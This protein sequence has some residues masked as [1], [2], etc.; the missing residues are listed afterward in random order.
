MT[1]TDL[2]LV[3]AL[4]SRQ[5]GILTLDDLL[6][7]G[8][9][10][11][12]T[13]SW[14]RTGRLIQVH[15]GVYRVAGAP[16]SFESGAFAAVVAHGPH[17]W[18]ADRTA[19]ALWGIDGF[20]ADQGR[21]HVLRTVGL[22]NQRVGAR[23]HRS[24]TV[25]DHHVT[26]HRSIPVTTVSR[27][28]FD[29]ARTVGPIR[30]DRAVES[31]LRTRHCTI[32]SLYRVFADLGG[33]GRPGTRRMREILGTRGRGYVPTESE[34]D[35]VGRAVV[36]SLGGF[37]W[38]VP[39]SDERGYI[40]RVDGLHRAS[41][42][43]I[44]WDGAAFHDGRLASAQDRAGDERLEALGLAVRRF[45]WADVTEHAELTRRTVARL[46]RPAAA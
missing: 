21:V 46:I 15:R 30:M 43:V 24:T 28:L 31:A 19:G 20:P 17:T 39:I 35:V 18:A 25:P 3:M 27:T 8:I 1:S 29:L 16:A 45:R 34:L 13:Q 6:A 26:V 7:A 14:A 41:R 9:G 42:L 40:R 23:V 32:A 44:E 33:R 11:R 12:R 5:H 37:E 10:E 2:S 22:S 38:Q 36:S 4:A